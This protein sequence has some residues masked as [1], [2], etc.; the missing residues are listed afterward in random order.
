MNLATGKRITRYQCKSLPITATIINRVTNFAL[1]HHVPNINHVFF[2]NSEIT[3][4]YPIS[5][6]PPPS[7]VMIL[8]EQYTTLYLNVTKLTHYLFP[9]TTVSSLQITTTTITQS[10]LTLQP[11][12]AM[13]TITNTQS[14]QQRLHFT[15]YQWPNQQQH[16]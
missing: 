2:R 8:K 3:F 16:N 13:L 9:K 14:K 4:T 6:Q 7:L 1:S 10:H 15:R 11:K 5:S 12:L